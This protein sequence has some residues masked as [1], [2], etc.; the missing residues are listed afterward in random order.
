MRTNLYTITICLLLMATC[1]AKAASPSAADGA[2]A[3]ILKASKALTLAE[4]ESDLPLFL[5]FYKADAISMPEYQ[6]T[7]TGISEIS[8]YYKDIF[9]RQKAKTIQRNIEEVI[10]L[11]DT[12]MEIGTFKKSYTDAASAAVTLTGKYYNVW[13]LLPSGTPKLKGECYGYF[14]PQAKP[15]VF[16]VKMDG[17]QQATAFSIDKQVPLD[18]KAYNALIAD[19]VRR[20]DGA[21]RAEIFTDDARVMP[22][23]DSTRA[24][25]ARIKPYLIA[26]NSGK[27]TIDSIT[28]ATY[29]QEGFGKYILE[30]TK[31]SV[32]FSLPQSK[33][34]MSGKGIRIWIRQPDHSLRLFREIGTHDH[35]LL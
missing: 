6:P 16:V 14:S 17:Q 15:D 34:H 35:I 21:G 22:H 10:K 28:V 29:H 20:R 23:A 33:G 19:D 27:V 5:S 18:L 4:Q 12:F 11:G 9:S 3:K 32:D 24:G 7:L 25:M 8:A 13:R 1:F 30:Y 26:Y 31:F 2:T